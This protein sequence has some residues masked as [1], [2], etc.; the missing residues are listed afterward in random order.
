MDIVYTIFGTVMT[1]SSVIMFSSN[2][3][4]LI[5]LGFGSLAIAI[6]LLLFGLLFDF[7]SVSK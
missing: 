1:I 7:S 5:M 3:G 4:V 6:I 2:N